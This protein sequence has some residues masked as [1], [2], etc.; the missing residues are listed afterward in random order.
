MPRLDTLPL[1]DRI[2]ALLALT[3]L[4]LF[5]TAIL[6]SLLT[7]LLRA[8]NTRKNRLRAGQEAKW[9]PVILEVLAGA[10]EPQSLTRFVNPGE[11]LPF[12]DYLLHY[13]RRIRGEETTILKDLATPFLPL[14]AETMSQRGVERR[15]RS[16]QTLGVLGMPEYVL[17]V[18][19]TLDDPSPLVS[20]IAAQSLSEH[21]RLEFFPS[22]L[23]QLHRYSD[24]HPAFL[25]GLLSDAGADA[26]PLLRTALGEGSRPGWERGIIAQALRNIRDLDSADVAAKVLDETDDPDLLVPCLRLVAELG[27]G[28]HRDALIPHLESL[29][30]PVRSYALRA[31]RTLRV[32]EDLPL[33]LRAL[34][35]E[36]PW[37]A[38]EAARGMRDLGAT[39]HLQALALSDEPRSAL[40]LQVMAE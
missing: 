20:I 24:W 23:Q 36:S 25:A 40:A 10:Q 17:V 7:V 39:A 11:E 30:F 9:D 19:D 35:D 1:D 22:I 28:R 16:V 27:E 4:G 12:L 32:S 8:N 13:F 33:F 3:I 29:H 6:F 2:F 37:V 5:L 38:M 31:L 26:A 14:L 21:G 34:E 15:A 18:R